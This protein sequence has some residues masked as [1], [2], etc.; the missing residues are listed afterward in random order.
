MAVTQARR[1]AAD[2][3][4]IAVE[5]WQ[6]RRPAGF[7]RLPY[8]LSR[9]FFLGAALVLLQSL[10]PLAFWLGPIVDF[11]STVF[12]PI[13][14]G[15]VAFAVFLLVLGAGLAR[16]KRIA[17]LITTV[18][19]SGLLLVDLFTVAVL[20]L[21][22]LRGQNEF[23]DLPTLARFGFNL[24]SLGAVY[25]VMMVYRGEFTARRQP[26]SI[27]KALIT[28]AVGLAI[29]F[30]V[31]VVLVALFPGGLEGPTGRLAWIGRRIAGVLLQ[32]DL[33]GG[34]PVSAPPGWI[35]TLIGL[36][37]GLTVL[38]AVLALMRSQRR[39]AL[40][41]AAD[42]PRIRALVA[43]S[44]DDSLAYFAT[45]RDKSVVFAADGRS[46]ILYRVDLGVCL[47][48]SDPIGPRD[49]W[50]GA[51]SAWRTLV[52]TYGWT[53]A[54]I[55]ASEVGATAYARAGLRVIRLGD[56]AIL[57]T[58]LFHLDEP[59]MRPVRQAVNRLE[60]L[61][62]TARI[63]RHRDIPHVELGDL[64]AK[65]VAWRDTETERGFS[66]ALG[67]LG[68][69][70]DGDCLMVEAIFPPDKRTPGPAGDVA[71]IL[72][73]VPWG[74]D[75]YSLDVMRRSPLADNGITE[76]MVTQ[77][78]AAGR[79]LGYRRV[80]LNFAV[81]RSA[82]EEGARIGAGPVLRLWRRMLLVASRW[83]QIESL[84]RSNVKYRP[85]WQ[86]RFLCFDETRDIALV[87]AAS[88]VAEGF[89]DLPRFLSAPQ[90][91]AARPLTEAPPV[92]IAAPA[93]PAGPRIPEQ[94]RQRMAVR[95]RLLADGVDP[96]PPSFRPTAR[97]AQLTDTAGPA[98]VRLAGRVLAIRDFG[99][100][101]FVKLR[102]WS[103]D[104]QL[105]L[106]R[107]ATGDDAMREFRRVVDLGDQLGAGG[108]VITSR[109]GEISLEVASWQ[110]TAKS[111]RPPPD[112]RRGITDPEAKVRQ[113]YLDLAVNRTARHQLAA[114]SRAIRAV[115]DTLDAR[116]YTEVETPILQTIHGGANA[117]PFRTH[118]NAYDLDLYLRIAPELYLKRLMVG[119]IDKIFE[120]GRNF[121]NEGAD[122]THNPE[123]T[124]LEAYEAYGDYT[125]MR[126]VAQEII[127]AAAQAVHGR[128]VVAGRDHLGSWHEVDLAQEWPVITVNDAISAAC[129]VPVSADTTR[130]ELVRIA[131]G[132]SIEMDSRW[133][134]GAVVLE[135]YEHL[136]EDVTVRPTFYTDFP[137]EVS[138]LTR[139]HRDDPRLAE[140][141]DLVAFGAEIGTAYSELVDPVEQRARLTAQSLQAAGGDPE[142]MELDE[143]F[144]MAL[145]F[146]MPP[147]GGL[148]M[149]LDRLIMLLTDTTIRETIAFPLVRPRRR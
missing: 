131:N 147:S 140:R 81:F 123:F 26:G 54:V 38:A 136:V 87:G 139:A 135:L 3:G 39:A 94:M 19:M 6:A 11:Y 84:F 138:P 129:G 133:T 97:C 61:G 52:E 128:T 112:K 29:T 27:R 37:V 78:M 4:G 65:T 53:P 22:V 124:M 93:A 121:R 28:L 95:E 141:W 132:L 149:G 126:L 80:S 109:S 114:R 57:E 115:R 106:T 96:Y 103:G 15:S 69:P 74:R 25:A 43:E 24:A 46:A 107:S 58:R 47:A 82:F 79:D 142:A 99:G 64:I 98:E 23:P 68:D 32:Q 105:M 100:V 146:A 21:L 7:R 119:G 77:L 10:F 9:L 72:S 75:G 83:W 85:Q 91:E 50:A 127:T 41:S 2:H 125:T 92:A 120:I 108:A 33:T 76:F 145:E 59:D 101:I 14:A 36:M 1:P 45:R 18:W 31:G 134:R 67:R 118:I 70:A 51:I 110:L 143:D 13:D 8:L 20:A 63:R 56:E 116:G 113:R 55:G 111:L 35:N 122:A 40:V 62:Y 17:W 89:I 86:P 16:R 42:E 73:F 90:V 117:R 12:V 148:G 34:A 71:G 30:T 49:H 137:A 104:A 5:P 130:D 60:K 88:G 144:L 44:E 102:D 66:M 48:S